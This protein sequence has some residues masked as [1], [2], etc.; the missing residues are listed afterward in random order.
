MQAHGPHFQ[1]NR[2]INRYYFWWKSK[3][4]WWKAMSLVPHLLRCVWL[5]SILE[6]PSSPRF[7]ENYYQT[8]NHRV[9]VAPIHVLGPDSWPELTEPRMG[10]CSM[11]SQSASSSS[12]SLGWDLRETSRELL[13]LAD[14]NIWNHHRTSRGKTNGNTQKQHWRSR[15]ESTW[16]S[17]AVWI[18]K[19]F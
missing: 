18:P 16:K 9:S 8:L 2:T 15:D 4:W 12:E 5:W 7:F 14:V 17:T 3:Q 6:N 10:M 1:V 19:S 11:R 13:Q